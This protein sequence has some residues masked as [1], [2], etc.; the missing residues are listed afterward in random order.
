MKTAFCF[1][2]ELRSIDKTYELI[3]SKIFSKFSD[4]DVFYH[5]WTDDPD[6]HKLH[7][8]AQDSHIKNIHLE[9]RKSF[10]EKNY[11]DHRYSNVNV[12]SLLGQLYCLKQ[13]NNLKSE[14]EKSNNF[15][16]DIVVRIR[17]DILIVN[18]TSLE[19]D[20]ESWNMSDHF[21]TTKHDDWFGYN[22]RFYFSNSENMDFISNRLDFLDFYKSTGGI[23]H[24][25]TF[26][27]FCV[28]YKN[29]QIG[30]SDMQF[31]LL[32]TDGIHSSELTG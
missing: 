12:Q 23:T 18:D 22:D 26:L 4:Y 19:N 1:S 20:I 28:D 10:D 6:L 14:Y 24:Y 17:P 15:K 30:R 7:H 13:C 31:M 11:G 5:S 25:E 29:I 32:R 8:L 9:N 16:Y 2:G 3:N 21:Y 27:K